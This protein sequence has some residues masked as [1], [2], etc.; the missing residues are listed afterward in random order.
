MK[1]VITQQLVKATITNIVWERIFVTFDIRIE[2]LTD[3]S[4]GD[5]TFYAV[6]E[7]GAAKARFRQQR[8]DNGNYQI[9]LNVTNQGEN[10]CIVSG[11]YWIVV[12]A[13]NRH[14]AVCETDLNLVNRLED[15]SRG[16]LYN[17]QKNV[18][19]VVFYVSEGEDTLPF[20]MRI[21]PAAK[22]GLGMPGGTKGKKR[23]TIKTRIKEKRRPFLRSIYQ[24]YAKQ[25]RNKK[26]TVL[27][28]SEQSDVL[29]RNLVAVRDRMK[30]RQMESTYTIL[31]S[32]RSAA[33]TRQSMKSWWLLVK[34]L[35]QSSVVVLDDHAPIL[36]WLTLDDNTKV[37]QL[38]HAGAGFKSSGYSRWGHDGCPAPYSAHRQYDFG[39]AGS[40]QI[41][42]FFSEVW[43][44]QDEQVLPTGMPRM[45]A[46]LDQN[47]KKEKLK[48][49]YEQYPMC[50]D[51]KVI[52]FAPTYRGRNK[53][54]AMYPYELIDFK[55]LYELC[56]EEYVVLFKMHPWVAQE[57]PIP[58]GYRD[59]FVDAN[60]YPDI[61]DL[62][63]M[64]DLLISDYSSNIY[65]Y[66]LMGKPML[67]FA[68]DE[69]Q[70]AFSRGFHRDYKASV[71]G[72]ICHTF[73]A[74]LDAIRNKDFEEEKVKQYVEHHFDYVDSNASD[75][76]I[77][78][79]ILGDL[80]KETVEE[81]QAIADANQCMNQQVFEIFDDKIV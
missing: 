64:T 59:K 42:P 25:Y 48:E 33:A 5:L 62:F 7:S 37:I 67:F 27:F 66:S 47:H 12:C 51:K 57:V 15:C 24:C 41:A 55:R 53:K 76:V 43:G 70:Y 22:T 17:R 23:K 36:D 13:G 35:A 26:N 31:E 75:R 60:Q 63:Y 69:I 16:F 8:Q 21:L 81:L 58:E 78:W 6:N 65:E 45:D 74:L 79:L 14:L 68:F 18:F 32:A 34:K 73:D 52:L 9:R 77:D 80:P 38:W 28:M 19:S 39:V 71:P 56:G 4:L 3:E 54:T 44:I 49:L 29:G 30:E 50:K 40:K 46:F 2:Q 72:K 20:R 1:K 10:H 61:N 11:N